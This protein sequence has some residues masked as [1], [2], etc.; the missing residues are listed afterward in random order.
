METFIIVLFCVILPFTVL[1]KPIKKAIQEKKNIKEFIIEYKVELI[2]VFILIIGSLVR[3]V[4]IGKIPNALNV[5]E[6]SSG[7]DGYSLMKNGID[8]G[9]NSYPVYL[10]A[11]GSGQSV[12]YSYL[13]IPILAFTGLT[14]YG[15]RLPMALVGII[16]LYVFYYL[17]KQVFENKKIA[18]VGTFFFAI[19]PWHIMKSRWGME[20]NLF[21]DLVLTST[22]FLI[23]GLKQ[24]KKSFQILACVVL[25]IS[26]YSYGTS[27]LF[28]PIF[29]LGVIAYLIHKKEITKKWAI[30]YL[31]IMFVLCI[32]II[33]YIAV[34]TFNLEQFKILGIT[35]PKLAANRQ[36][37]VTTIFSGNVVLNCFNNFLDTIKLII[38]QDDGLEWNAIS[39]YGMFYLISIIF[40][41]YGIHLSIKKYKDNKFNSI[42]NI[43]M[44]SSLVLSA[45]CLVNIN[46]LNILMIPCIY[47]ISLGLYEVFEKYKTM[48]PCIVIIY[49]YMFANFVWVYKNKDYN[50]YFTFESGI[51][52]V[53]DYCE[54]Q[55]NSE[56]YCK[57]SFKEPFIYFM[58]YNETD[59]Y[60]Y[61]ESV[62]YFEDGGIF[63]NIKSFGRYHFYLPDEVKE[64]VIVI[65]PKDEKFDYD[66]ELKEKNTVNQFDIYKF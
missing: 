37:A 56:I 9:G 32:S 29:V 26:S 63:D 51:K 47:Y 42:I 10:Y 22:L 21:P 19:C 50:N 15:I 65:V 8:R 23:L 33:L 17:L 40:F 35:I 36:E 20:C 18:L 62:Q 28:L 60:E 55:E 7:Y 34:N 11:W 48:I 4:A 46:R 57:Y 52:D 41:L 38:L 14:E 54:R 12:L 61:L 5:D 59:V 6:A 58:F 2:L 16:S 1:I 24:N 49:I 3:L 39:G 43:W 44:L 45:V 25:A 31:T 30:I 66:V 53:A 64:G 13:M 27:Y